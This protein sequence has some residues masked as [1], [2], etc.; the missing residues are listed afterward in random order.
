MIRKESVDPTK[1]AIEYLVAWISM[2]RVTAATHISNQLS[3]H[4]YGDMNNVVIGFLNLS[5]LTLFS[6]MKEKGATAETMTEASMAWLHKLSIDLE[7]VA[8]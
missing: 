3:N 4:G 7:Q 1:E 8:K 2:D 5:M 6:L